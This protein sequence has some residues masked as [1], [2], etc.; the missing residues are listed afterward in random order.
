[1]IRKL[2]F[3]CFCLPWLLAASPTVWGP[4][5][6]DPNTLHLG[7]VDV[8]RGAYVECARDMT[9]AGIEPL[10][11]ERLYLSGPCSSGSIGRAWQLN[12]CRFIC[13]E[14]PGGDWS[15]YWESPYGGSQA[16]TWNQ[17]RKGFALEQPGLSCNTGGGEISGR[18]NP[19]STLATFNENEATVYRGDGERL[20]YKVGVK[21]GRAPFIGDTGPN[22]DPRYYIAYLRE[23][24]MPSGRRRF[25]TV[26]DE[27]VTR[28]EARSPDGLR[29]LGHIDYD[30]DR[31]KQELLATGSDGGWAKIKVGR[32]WFISRVDL[33]GDRWVEYHYT[34]KGKVQKRSTPDGRYLEIDYHGCGRVKS[35]WVPM[36]ISGEKMQI[37][38]FKYAQVGR[39]E[40]RRILGQT[41]AI[42]ICG[43][44][45]HYYCFNWNRLA[46][47]CRYD[48]AGDGLKLLEHIRFHWHHGDERSGNLRKRQVVGPG[49][50]SLRTIL[51]EYDDQENVICETLSGDLIGGCEH[52]NCPIHRRFDKSNRLLWSK[53]GEVERE[54]T[55]LSET[56]LPLR[57]RFSAAGELLREVSYEYDE[58]H[59][60][61][62]S[63]VE[64]AGVRLATR[65][66]RDDLG[67][68][69]REE[70]LCGI[71][72][73]LG[74]R[75]FTY[76]SFQRPT[77]V[78]YFDGRGGERYTCEFGYDEAG[79]LVYSTDP[80]GYERSWVYDANGNLLE[81]WGPR[82]GH[83]RLHS[84]NVRNARTK[85]TIV[86]GQGRRD[87]HYYYDLL[88]RCNA[89]E[90][91]LG[92]RW[93]RDFDSMGRVTW[94]K[95]AD[96]AEERFEY[97]RLGC[98]SR[99]VN[100]L[101]G[102]THLQHTARGQP[103]YTR[104]PDGTEERIT[105]D[106]EGRAVKSCS[107]AGVEAVAAYDAAGRLTSIVV[108]EKTTRY[109]YEGSR[110][111]KSTDPMGLERFYD[112]DEAGRLV[113]E[114]VGE[115][116]IFYGYDEFGRL[117]ET[118]DGDRCVRKRFD[119]LGRVIAEE[120]L[121]G[122]EV[123]RRASYTYDEVG[124]CLSATVCG[125]TTSTTYDFLNRPI[126]VVGPDGGET[127]YEYEPRLV[128]ITDPLGNITERRVD[129]MGRTV[130]MVRTDGF[131]ILSRV[132]YEYDIAGNCVCETYDAKKPRVLRRFFDKAGRL[133]EMVT[134]DTI[135]TVLVYNELGQLAQRRVSIGLNTSFEYDR[136]GRLC[137]EQGRD[138]SYDYAYDLAD[139]LLCATD[140]DGRATKRSY[141][142]LGNLIAER[143]AS[144]FEI[145]YQRDDRGRPTRLNLSDQA[146]IGYEYD[147][148]SLRR[149]ISS[150]GHVHSY[151]AF[152]EAGRVIRERCMDGAEV[153][154]SFD[155][156]G[157]LAS[158]EGADY[159]AD[160][161]YDAVG[162]L[163]GVD[164]FDR[165]GDFSHSYSYNAR[166]QLVSEDD[167]HTW[168]VDEFGNWVEADGLSFEYDY[169][170]RRMDLDYDRHGNMAAYSF[171][172]R[173]RLVEA[174]GVRHVYD[175]FDRRV[176]SIE[177]GVCTS[178]LYDGLDEVGEFDGDG[179]LVTTRLLGLGSC[180]DI[181]AM[182]GVEH[183]KRLLVPLSN[184]RGDVVQLRD[185]DG[186][187]VETCRYSAY[188]E[189]SSWLTIPWGFQSKRVDLS[190]L[191]YFGRRFYD[192][193]LGR[194]VSQDPCG[195]V[196]GPNLYTYARS[197]PT[198]FCDPRGCNCSGVQERFGYHSERGACQ[199]EDG[200]WE[201]W[202][203]IFG[204]GYAA[205]R[206]VSTDPPAAEPAIGD[207]WAW[208]DGRDHSDNAPTVL[209]HIRSAEVEYVKNRTTRRF[210]R[211][212]VDFSW[213]DR[214]R[215]DVSPC[216][217]RRTDG[218]RPLPPNHYVVYV[219]GMHTTFDEAKENLCHL[220][221]QMGN[222]EIWGVHN[223]THGLF[224]D[225]R[226]CQRG[227]YRNIATGP[228]LL[229]AGVVRETMASDP[230]AVMLII[231]HSQ[232]AIHT[233]HALTLLP[234]EMREWIMVLAIA[235][236][237]R[238]HDGL[239][240]NTVT[241]ISLLDFVPYLDWRGAMEHS[242]NVKLLVPNGFRFDHSVTSPTW[243]RGIRDMHFDFL[244]WSR[245]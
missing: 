109:E 193:G 12:P 3:F 14:H 127:T 53:E 112:Y 145:R 197:C 136:Y 162:N 46:D 113:A 233:K 20:R 222:C 191:I 61:V 187:V 27:R 120:E 225:L 33:P 214:C 171:D 199:R 107:R 15:C 241:L 97:D 153:R 67:R 147:G 18:T 6:I 108:G 52:Q 245:P 100:A 88:G 11:L 161:T 45:V 223:P 231:C 7:C 91:W 40:G 80:M 84:Y 58:N 152:D 221:A 190:G 154:R 164:G 69:V 57:E 133:K 218:F 131:S 62:L 116:S 240:A 23:R 104:Y 125:H 144:G 217:Y 207:D 16:F 102:E 203:I 73:L 4:R 48:Q 235:P 148:C 204:D 35:L 201:Y 26:K 211:P 176:A 143:Q 2:L 198:A 25:Y 179:D 110:I 37:A 34:P 103:Y 158:M 119:L 81:E 32:D 132:Q 163:V 115:R 213:D 210:D 174:D 226:E 229:L 209:P 216:L 101:G 118:V 31:Q 106:L 135:T 168:S 141:D 194:F 189:A 76:D 228:A 85:T 98:C 63:C 78:T 244:E 208:C 82:P 93:E 38:Q 155:K 184:Y 19:K 39:F 24:E 22:D 99:R 236:A 55:Y 128:R 180:G 137:R 43:N 139:R 96:G 140:Q 215:D 86:G 59:A 71:D 114:R 87:H 47:L 151:D 167:L 83:G 227:L 65:T 30:W 42:D 41:R 66:E 242:A 159:Q 202:E 130:E 165:E 192:P 234:A 117:C 160:L 175:A 8:F 50:G 186:R 157:R 146:S 123:R 142:E 49:G 68:V 1:M 195:Y 232:G 178:Y 219:N 129:C 51:Y 172:A 230:D 121:N 75:E 220:S 124:N 177:D 74:A 28:I 238:I 156:M 126:L 182:V 79:R 89:E 206:S 149:V 5:E 243:N 64:E 111:V 196:D 10:S 56:D 185:D 200:G 29:L 138:F 212:M 239:C 169:G 9:V 134:P 94:T 166:Y 181:G 92:D 70:R 36:G 54:I 205:G 237:M 150:S 13:K 77:H 90:N 170:N 224:K 183:C 122:D 60:V 95:S 17:R 21:T 188:G 105:Y 72:Q 173:G 44:E